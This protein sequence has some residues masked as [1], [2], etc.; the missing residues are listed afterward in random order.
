MRP[1]I[2]FLVVLVLAV[3]GIMTI[4]SVPQKK[5]NSSNRTPVRYGDSE[6]LLDQKLRNV[7]QQA[8]DAINSTR[9]L[10]ASHK[11]AG[12]GQHVFNNN[13]LKFHRKVLQ[14]LL[15]DVGGYEQLNNLLQDLVIP[16]SKAQRDAIGKTMVVDFSSDEFYVDYNE[17]LYGEYARQLRMA[18]VAY[19]KAHTSVYENER[20]GAKENFQ[21]VQFIANQIVK[22]DVYVD[23]M[24]R[25]RWLQENKN[26]LQQYNNIREA[27][28]NMIQ[29]IL[30]VFK[31]MSENI[32]GFR[33]RNNWNGDSDF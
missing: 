30:E 24:A 29:N 2:K 16:L 33:E 14:D 22:H 31:K 18:V 11:L 19:L 21:R 26:R 13:L 6:N 5:A 20:N 10:T 4:I 7:A 27:L 3:V 32:K 25:D 9:T 17:D 1:F 15:R 28:M 12:K 23:P 8:L